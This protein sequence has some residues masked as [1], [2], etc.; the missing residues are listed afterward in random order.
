ME[1]KLKK[2]FLLRVENQNEQ[3]LCNDFNIETENIVRNNNAYPIFCGEYVEININDYKTHFV[4]P[5][6]TLDDIAKI[7]NI[8]SEKIS[9][10]NNLTSPKLF[11][12]QRLKIYN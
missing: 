9:A 3:Q 5:A 6:Q 8:S 12:G 4:K 1:L 10:D 11:I 7:Y 2:Q